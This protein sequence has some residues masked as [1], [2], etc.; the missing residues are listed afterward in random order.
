MEL[1][2]LLLY[3]HHCYEKDWP[4]CV[5][6]YKGHKD[7]YSLL[8]WAYFHVGLRLERSTIVND[9]E[10]YHVIYTHHGKNLIWF[11][12]SMRDQKNIA[13]TY[14]GYPILIKIVY[15]CFTFFLQNI[16]VLSQKVGKT[17]T[18]IYCHYCHFFQLPLKNWR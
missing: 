5:S 8:F 7:H 6:V 1:H 15:F 11:M 18:S 2:S 3:Q 4:T 9:F 12:S 17:L 14:Y 16:L 13:M 10:F